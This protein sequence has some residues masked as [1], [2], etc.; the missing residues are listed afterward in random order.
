M[1]QFHKE[2]KN[3]NK[4][5]QYEELIKLFS[6]YKQNKFQQIRDKIFFANVKLVFSIS[7]KYQSPDIDDIE[8]YGF[9]GLVNAIENFDP[10]KN[11]RFSTYATRCIT[12]EIQRGLKQV[13]NIVSVP[14]AA[15]NKEDY[16]KPCFLSIDDFEPDPENESDFDRQLFWIIVQ[17]IC[18]E[19]ETDI[20]LKRFCYEEKLTLAKIGS[21]WNVAPDQLSKA[22]T[23]LMWKKLNGILKKLRSNEILKKY[24]A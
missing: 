16:T 18:T 19:E 9:I 8:Q 12:N 21:N 23:Q 22:P 4:E 11:I 15:Q 10:D 17:Q 13:N 3:V 1:K 5:L 20:L 14:I 2:I 24:Y 7:K 6:E